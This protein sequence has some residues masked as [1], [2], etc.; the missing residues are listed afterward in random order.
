MTNF[1][2]W[3]MLDVERHNA[4]VRPENRIPVRPDAVAAG[5]EDT[6][7]DAIVDECKR[8]GWLFFHGSMAHRAMRT[9]GE[10]DFTI[11]ADR[12]RVFFIEAK[13]KTGKL[14]REQL[15]VKAWAAKLGHTVHVVRSIREFREVVR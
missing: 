14:S 4:M 9:K 7:H 5:A 13:T 3:T 1:R 15:G 10:P 8:R 6:L 2:D 12:G 11:C